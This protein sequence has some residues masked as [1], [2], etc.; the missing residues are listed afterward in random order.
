MACI[1]YG[2][3]KQYLRIV[4]VEVRIALLAEYIPYAS[5]FRAGR[6]IFLLRSSK[7]P[8]DMAPRVL[9]RLVQ[10]RIKVK[11]LMWLLRSI[12]MHIYRISIEEVHPNHSVPRLSKR[13]ANKQAIGKEA[14]DVRKVEDN[15]PVV[16]GWVRLGDIC[17]D[18]SELLDSALRFAAVKVAFQAAS[19]RWS[20]EPVW[21]CWLRTSGHVWG[22][23]VFD[24]GESAGWVSPV[25]DCGRCWLSSSSSANP[26]SLCISRSM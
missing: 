12:S 23:F 20:G 11:V 2:A 3:P 10:P 5:I 1:T 6:A 21:L 19:S 24:V 26:S 13:V 7:P 9:M 18:V 8:I 17:I 14:I 15:V 22:S 25:V 4:R 16:L